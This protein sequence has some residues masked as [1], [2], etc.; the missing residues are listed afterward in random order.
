VGASL[1]KVVLGPTWAHLSESAR[2]LFAVM[3]VTAKD[4]D[5]PPRYFGG[6]DALVLA[7]YG[8][9][10]D[11]PLELRSQRQYVRQ[12]IKKIRNAGGLVL[13][14]EGQ[15]RS[16]QG[17]AVY[18]IRV[19][20]RANV[21]EPATLPPGRADNS[22]TGRALNSPTGRAESVIVGEPSALPKEDRGTTK[23]LTEG[24]R[25]HL[26]AQLTL[27]DT[28]D[29]DEKAEVKCGACGQRESVCRLLVSKRPGRRHD[30]IPA[31]HLTPVRTA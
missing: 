14:N 28:P 9:I 4:D 29:A 24:D 18:E 13:A 10:A 20:T 7:F 22:P 12:L 26:P 25:G 3:A 16:G 17:R 19:F 30:F 21:G 8:R 11:D 23:G 2:L 27:G 1:A 31:R 15:I 5:K 6:R